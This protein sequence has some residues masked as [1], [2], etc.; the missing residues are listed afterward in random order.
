MLSR[1]P[2]SLSSDV[3]DAVVTSTGKRLFSSISHTVSAVVDR[4]LN[5]EMVQKM[6]VSRAKEASAHRNRLAGNRIFGFYRE[7]APGVGCMCGFARRPSRNPFGYA[8]SVKDSVAAGGGLL[9]GN[10][11]LGMAAIGTELD[12]RRHA[13]FLG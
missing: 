10:G 2:Q 8:P 3:S 12:D 13:R 5:H 6:A 4:L 9:P 7:F 1:C 11:E